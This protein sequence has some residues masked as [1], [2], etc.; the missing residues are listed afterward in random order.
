MRMRIP[1]ITTGILAGALLIGCG[2]DRT[3]ADDLKRETKEAGSAAA[4]Y[5]AE[6]TA[7]ARAALS[8]RADQLDRR[9]GELAGKT[10]NNSKKMSREARQKSERALAA[11][12][13]ESAG[14][15]N[16]LAQMQDSAGD[17]WERLKDETQNALDKAERAADSA[18]EEI[19]N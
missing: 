14:V 15:K 8:R 7:E 10:K 17:G 4:D 9:I 13:E 16:K 6:K 18:W 2:G 5:T 3:T 12:R 19:K 1:C 11:L